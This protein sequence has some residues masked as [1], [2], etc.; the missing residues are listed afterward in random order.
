METNYG[1]RV[2]HGGEW[3]H[4]FV[5][6]DNDLSVTAETT[7]CPKI[8]A[9]DSHLVVFSRG[10]ISIDFIHVHQHYH[11][12]IEDISRLLP[13]QWCNT[14]E[15]DTCESTKICNIA[16]IKQNIKKLVIIYA[17][18]NCDVSYQGVRYLFHWKDDYDQID[19]ALLVAKYLHIHTCMLTKFYMILHDFLTF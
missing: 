16:T 12:G 18:S 10:L 3:H 19:T 7:A 6:T 9:Y 14:E 8:Q 5:S 2:W 15:G 4:F 1:L 17:N 13:Y 11:T